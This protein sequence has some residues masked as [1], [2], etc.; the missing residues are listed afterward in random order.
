MAVAMKYMASNFLKPEKFKRVELRRWRKKMHFLLSSM[1][2]LY[3]LTTPVP[4]DG[5][6]NPTVEQVYYVTYVSKAYF[7]KDND[8]AWWVDS[9]ATVRMCKDRCCF[10]TYES[11]NDGSILHMK[12]E[13][14]TLVHGCGCV[15]LRLNIVSNNIGSA[16]MSTSKLN[17]SIQWHARLGHVYFKRMQDMSKDGLILAFDMETEKF[18]INSIVES[19]DDIFD[20][21]IFSSVP[22]LSQRS[23]VKG[24]KASGGSVVPE[25][26][27]SF[28]KEAI[29]DE[30][31]SIMG[32]NTWV[33]AYLPPVSTL[34]DTTEKLMPDN[35]QAVSQLEYSRVIGCLMYPMTCT[36][37]DIAF[38]MG[39]LSMYT[40]KP[41]T[42]HW[43]TIQRA[44]KK[45][46]YTIG[47]T[48]KSEFMALAAAGKEAEW[49]KN[50]ILEI[51]L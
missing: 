2:V 39:K 30:I 11:L 17:D 13:L 42:Q 23:L 43:Q 47:S 7:V 27:V 8:V 21:N 46:T 50:L 19:S 25:K 28:W 6:D 16:F 51:P 10:K 3:V 32:N 26:D 41:G 5:G 14:T 24:T 38:A 22:R 44:S 36:R 45:Q 20:E 18:A 29:N 31:D 33:L 49:L 48:M 35:G 37:L 34:M 12:N 15:D 1:S 40:S 4:E 9:G